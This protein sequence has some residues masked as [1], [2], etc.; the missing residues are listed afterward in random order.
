[1]FSRKAVFEFV[2]P[3]GMDV[4]EL[5]LEL[6]DAGLD[7]IEENEGEYYAYADYTNFGEMV[8]AFEKLNIEVKKAVLKRFAN[9]PVEFSEEQLEDIEKMLD[10]LEEDDDVQA[11]YT[12]IA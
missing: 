6:I 1:M 9:D 2:K 7:E 8:H 5:E 10:K 12:N 4:E 3:A 11:V